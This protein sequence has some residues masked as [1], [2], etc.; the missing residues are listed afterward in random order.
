[1]WTQFLLFPLLVTLFINLDKVLTIMKYLLTFLTTLWQA[2][3]NVLDN[4][5]RNIWISFELCHGLWMALCLLWWPDSTERTLEAVEVILVPVNKPLLLV[6]L[7]EHWVL[8]PSLVCT[9]SVKIG[10]CLNSS[11]LCERSEGSTNRGIFELF[12]GPRSQILE[13]PWSLLLEVSKCDT[14]AQLCKDV[15]R[16]KIRM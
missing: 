8:S 7:T 10:R 9:T 12:G 6:K 15:A 5:L 4:F 16:K 13:C 14:T 11:T 3:F 2:F 1:M